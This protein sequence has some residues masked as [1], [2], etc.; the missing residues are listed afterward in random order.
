MSASPKSEPGLEHTYLAITISLKGRIVH[1][2]WRKDPGCGMV[3]DTFFAVQLLAH[4]QK[5][6]EHI[7]YTCCDTAEQGSHGRV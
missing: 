1:L 3:D 6:P 7:H 5:L 4:S 2:G